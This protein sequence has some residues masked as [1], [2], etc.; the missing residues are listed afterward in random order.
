YD[1]LVKMVQA[2]DVAQVASAYQ[3]YYPLF[4]EA[5]QDLGYP[6]GYFNDR[7][8]EV[9]DHLLAT[10]EGDGPI[11]LTRPSVY[12]EFADAQLEALA[13]G[14]KTLIRIGPR[15]AAVVKQKLRELRQAVAAQQS[16]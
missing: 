11:R 2:M 13:V 6:D 9:S 4:Q 8:V 15:N 7:L 5:Y 14:Q 12:Y 3:R 10:P 16:N 1:A